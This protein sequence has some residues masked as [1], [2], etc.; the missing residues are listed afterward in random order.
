ME[1]PAAFEAVDMHGTAPAD[2]DRAFAWR[3]VHVSTPDASAR[4]PLVVTLTPA[5]DAP[6]L[7]WQPAARTVRPIQ[8]PGDALPGARVDELGEFGDGLVPARVQ[9]PASKSSAAYAVWGYVDLNGAWVIPPRLLDA[10]AFQ[11]GVA[12]VRDLDGLTH[13]VDKQGRMLPWQPEDIAWG[14]DGDPFTRLH[15]GRLGRWVRITQSNALAKGKDG[16]IE[17]GE[18]NWLF[19]GLTVVH[20]PGVNALASAD[21]ELWVV[22]SEGDRKLWTPKQGVVPAPAP[23]TPSRPLDANRFVAPSARAEGVALVDRVSGAI[24]DPAPAIVAALT[25]SRFLACTTGYSEDNFQPHDVGRLVGP[26]VGDKRCGVLDNSGRWWLAP[27]YATIDRWGADTLVVQGEQQA[28]VVRLDADRPDCR[29]GDG[30]LPR[31]DLGPAVPRSWRYADADG[32]DAWTG[33]Y[34]EAWPFAG[35]VAVATADSLPGLIDDK[36]RWLTPRVEGNAFARAHALAAVAPRMGRD[37]YREGVGLIDRGGHWLVPPVFATIFR[38]PDGTLA[39]CSAGVPIYEMRA[40]CDHVDASGH[41]LAS[42]VPPEEAPIASA[43]A[44]PADSGHEHVPTG[45]VAVARNGRWGFRDTKGAWTIPPRFDDAW[46]FEG[47]RAAV[48]IDSPAPASADNPGAPTRRWGLVAPDGHWVAEPRFESLGRFQGPVAAARAEGQFGLVDRDGRWVAQPDFTSIS[49][50]SGGVA[51]ATRPD[52]TICTLDPAGRCSGP[53]GLV[54][55]KRGADTWAVATVKDGKAGR[56]LTGYLD[57][58]SRWAIPP[59]YQGAEP[60][61]GATAIVRDA[62]PADPPDWARR[63]VTIDVRWS[64]PAR[65]AIVGAVHPSAV[66]TKT[67]PSY[68]LADDQGRWLLLRRSASSPNP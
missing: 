48:A 28:C 12:V 56:P 13:L 58:D 53:A 32:H 39:A 55:L 7:V 3:Q 36:G 24:L 54:E 65:L 34:H 51:T 6:P 41:V 11:R 15:V 37:W 4:E 60:F 17:P 31:F 1:A 9:L 16:Q 57:A 66:D 52:G 63:W 2:L 61:S 20:V 5:G 42:P 19:D 30:P 40:R 50:F 18:V 62:L 8:P 35:R 45:P 43:A 21:G 47:D 22:L 44:T 46:D 27:D 14:L 23:Y 10:G 49:Q 29:R 26:G 64:A 67:P 33:R 25:P 68:A 59:R 38:L